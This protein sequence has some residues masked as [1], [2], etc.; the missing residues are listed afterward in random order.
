MK[1]DYDFR[2]YTA[3]TGNESSNSMAASIPGIKIAPY[4]D[5]LI[6]P[7]GGSVSYYEYFGTTYIIWNVSLPGGTTPTIR[8]EVRLSGA[9]VHI[10][11]LW[12]KSK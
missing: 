2:K 8:F 4:W 5:D 1:M 10:L 11:S 3:L 7:T 9:G 12:D 6:T